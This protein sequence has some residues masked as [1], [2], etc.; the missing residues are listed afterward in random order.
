[1]EK[2]YPKLFYNYL[3]CNNSRL[4]AVLLTFF[5]FIATSIHSQ[6]ISYQDFT[7]DGTYTVPAEASVIKVEAWGGGGAGGSASS[8][9]TLV[10]FVNGGG[11]GG[12]GAYNRDFFQVEAAQQYAVTI[13]LGGATNGANGGNSQV[14]GTGGL[15][16][17]NGGA[18][19]INGYT[20][21]TL[22]GLNVISNHGAG[23][24]GGTGFYN[25]GTG[26]SGIVAHSGTG[27][28]GA[29]NT[30]IGGNPSGSTGGLGGA[31]SVSGG[32]GANSFSAQ[33]DGTDGSFP[34]GGGSGGRL[35]G[36]VGLLTVKAGGKG[37]DG[38]VRITAYRC[39]PTQVATWNGTSWTNGGPD[40]TKTAVIDGAY[41]TNTNGSFTACS[42]QVNVGKTL[43]IGTS[44]NIEVYNEVTNNGGTIQVA[45]DASLVQWYSSISNAG[46]VKVNRNTTPMYRY[47]FTY[48]SSPVAGM[49]MGTLSPATLSDKYYWWNTA[50]Q[51]WVINSGGSL[52]MNA[53]QGYIIRAPQ[54]YSTNQSESEVF[55]GTFEGVPHN[56]TITFPVVGDGTG[57]KYNLIGNPYPSAISAEDFL[58]ENS[59]L[60]EGTIHFWTHSSVPVFNEVTETYVYRGADYISYNKTGGTGGALLDGNI[61]SGQS[62]FVAGLANGTVTFNNSMRKLTD[63]NSF[64]KVTPTTPID[65]WELVGKHRVWLNIK[66]AQGA[67]N[68]A[69]V[70][71]VEN[72][73]D[74]L[75]W[76][77]DGETFS[78]NEVSL[79]SIVDNK[80]LSIQ[81]RALPFSEQDVVHLGYTN[82]QSTTLKIGIDHLDGLLNGKNI[83]LK[84]NVLNIYHNLKLS[85]YTFTSAAG[86]FNDRFELVYQNQALS[87]G[88]ELINPE[89][90]L[91]FKDSENSILVN[92]GNKSINDIR[93]YD[94]SG[95]MLYE[96]NEI[97]AFETR[98]Q[99]ITTQHQVLIVE[100]SI[101]Q[102]VKVTKKIIF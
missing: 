15:L 12:G 11:G 28:G 24:A 26:S 82:T 86:T 21:V 5:I 88:D 38:F 90:I 35:N 31:G 37:G 89:S 77:Y 80:T 13:G 84:D 92:A 64:Y 4:N 91:V 9:L 8:L 30:A 83:F 70:G 74:G 32:N 22:G 99:N 81:G 60:I 56:G 46:V 27:A 18:G 55:V 45:N 62:F 75:D 17:A 61:A 97:N 2:R 42:C 76:G 6:V 48:W 14:A 96:K 78:G 100:V 10:S 72:A 95:R 47:D 69:L 25:G 68:Q 40:R 3:S 63:N 59:S 44:N 73:T 16:V 23:G 49:T 1:M 85:D 39:D 53:G 52:T 19:G 41:D 51:S 94:L 98:L 50:T 71:Y 79:Y 66:S 67:F 54:T 33:S 101:N 36:I 43:T 7:T 58:N 93:I 20:V 29:G 34:S 65:N 87:I 102:A 57:E